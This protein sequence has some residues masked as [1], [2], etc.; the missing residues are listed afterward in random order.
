M[1]AQRILQWFQANKSAKSSATKDTDGNSVGLLFKVP[2]KN[3]YITIRQ[4]VTET[5]KRFR[6]KDLQGR[7]FAD[8]FGVDE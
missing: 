2:G 8:A 3:R 7:S 5:N 4:D 6:A 1:N